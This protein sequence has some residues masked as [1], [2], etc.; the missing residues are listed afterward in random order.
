MCTGAVFSDIRIGKQVVLFVKI[1]LPAPGVHKN[2]LPSRE[3]KV[4]SSNKRVMQ[5]ENVWTSNSI[6]F[7]CQ[8]HLKQDLGPNADSSDSWVKP[9]RYLPGK[10]IQQGP[11]AEF[12][13]SINKL[14]SR[15]QENTHP[16][17]RQDLAH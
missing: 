5:T 6:M 12:Q 17:K 15:T 16:T 2:D 8:K 11:L 1:L 14:K 4:P 10:H 13:N 3:D 7:Y 9:Y